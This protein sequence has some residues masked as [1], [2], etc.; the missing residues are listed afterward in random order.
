LLPV[1]VP[2]LARVRRQFDL[3][4]SPRAVQAH[5]AD[6]PTLGPRVRARPGLRVAGAF[7]AAQLA[8]RTVLGQ[9]VSVRGA[10]TIAGRLVARWGTPLPDDARAGA[11]P[12]LTHLPVALDALVSAGAQA[13][14]TVGLPGQRATALVTLARAIIDGPLAP[15]TDPVPAI[16]PSQLLRTLTALP[17]IG[18]WTAQYI[19]MRGLAWPDAFP[20]G[21]LV[22][23]QAMGGLTAPRLI[24]AAERWRPWRA[25]AAHQL[26]AGP[27]PDSISEDRA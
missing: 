14:A 13:V 19:A 6:D 8:L 21:D 23:R 12:A 3:D 24:E 26:W 4:A 25:Y 22:L 18:D 1:L 2:L 7:D 5:L 16:E 27:P 17:G 11:P 15:L 20:A 9:Q 10:T